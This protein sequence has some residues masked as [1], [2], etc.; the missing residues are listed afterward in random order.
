MVQFEEP[1]PN[2]GPT[3]PHLAKQDA[4]AVDPSQ[5]TALTP[6]VVR[7]LTVLWNHVYIF[8]VRFVVALFVFRTKYAHTCHNQSGRFGQF[9]WWHFNEKYV[10]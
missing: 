10:S 4:S 8:V 2:P 6:E 9:L 7:S 1:E 3:Q 5:L